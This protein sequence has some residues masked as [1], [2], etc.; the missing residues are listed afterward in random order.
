[1]WFISKYRMQST[2]QVIPS[3]NRAIYRILV[4]CRFG[5]P[6]WHPHRIFNLPLTNFI[7]MWK[8]IGVFNSKD[9]FV[10]N[11][12]FHKPVFQIA[13][14]YICLRLHFYLHLGLV[15]K[16]RHTNYFLFGKVVA[17]YNWYT[18]LSSKHS[19]FLQFFYIK[20]FF[21]K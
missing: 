6:K 12:I 20:F 13:N 8:K 11:I 1:M 14:P 19:C 3:I 4:S 17:H 18:V 16:Y 21:I 15:T 2:V 5:V 10:E 9:I 7:W